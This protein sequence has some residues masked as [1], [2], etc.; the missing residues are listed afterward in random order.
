MRVDVILLIYNRPTHLKS[1]LQGLVDNKITEVYVY[2]DYSDSI[3]V[4]KNQQIMIEMLHALQGCKVHLNKRQEHYGLAKSV[5]SAINER[6]ADNADAIVLLEDDCVLKKE[7]FSFFEE[8]LRE[9]FGN[10]QIRSLCGYRFPQCE[11]VSDPKKDLLLLFRFSTWGWATWRDRWKDYEPNL[12]KLLD[13]V[14]REGLS[15]KDFAPDIARL[16]ESRKYLEGKVD[17][18]SINWILAHYIDASFCVYPSESIIENI[19]MDGSGKNCHAT[20]VFKT[21]SVSRN[22][23]GYYNW[24]ELQFFPENEKMVENFMNKYSHMTY[25]NV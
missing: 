3:E 20:E 24:K 4:Q 14:R 21:E 25:P 10:K 19:G 23:V 2:I 5:V 17:I 9:L 13:G 11:F 8:G 6:F 16:C 18:W 22:L 1:V 15:I 12:V 7:G